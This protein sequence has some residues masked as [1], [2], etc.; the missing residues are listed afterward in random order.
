[1]GFALAQGPPAIINGSF[2]TY[3]MYT[4][5]PT[6]ASNGCLFW[7][8]KSSFYGA[9][10]FKNCVTNIQL[11]IPG[12]VKADSTSIRI[13]FAK[14]CGIEK[15]EFVNP[16]DTTDLKNLIQE[17]AGAQIHDA[18]HNFDRTYRQEKLDEAKKLVKERVEALPEDDKIHAMME[19]SG[20]DFVAEEFK[21]AEKKVMRKMILEEGVR[22]DGRKPDPLPGADGEGPPRP[23][24][25]VVPDVFR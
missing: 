23:R 11:N 21:A 5:N 20:I 8:S 19:E 24:K 17:V 3:L 4:A 16:Y 1:M 22:A 6:E 10:S 25:P 9:F 12:L 13:A 2:S 15:E 14:E 7:N 18:Y